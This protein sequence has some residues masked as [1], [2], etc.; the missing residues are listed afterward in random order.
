MQNQFMIISP[1]RFFLL[2]GTLLMSFPTV[3]QQVPYYSA[4]RE[5]WG[6]L[7]PAF[8]DFHY[9]DY[10]KGERPNYYSANISLRHQFA[11][12]NQSIKQ[13]NAKIESRIERSKWGLGLNFDQIG[14]F[15][16]LGV[17]G[18]YGYQV[19]PEKL[20]LAFSPKIT[21]QTLNLKEEDFANFADDQTA[22]QA[23][24]FSTIKTSLDVGMSYANEIGG[25]NFLL[26][27]LGVNNFWAQ[28]T[29][30]ILTLK[31]AP[32]LN[33]FAGFLVSYK[34]N[35]KSAD[36]RQW[37][38]MVLF[39]M[40]PNVSY[41]TFRDF[42]RPIVPSIDFSVRYSIIRDSKNDWR[43]G[44]GL[45]TSGQINFEVSA[46]P[47]KKKF[48]FGINFSIPL[49]NNSLGPGLEIFY[50]HRN[51]YFNQNPK[52]TGKVKF[53]RSSRRGTSNAE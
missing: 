10:V 47:E 22:Q 34:K 26:L 42:E 30:G 13:L 43:T 8:L 3:A 44:A 4:I 36:I 25:K 7:N 18:Q 33:A 53:K 41:F 37:E 24:A 2:L 35:G 5:N 21:L 14:I 23:I 27:G 49:L 1:L 46:F 6:L 31:K 40:V 51:N 48:D 50:V 11:N 12:E 39:R 28:Q 45:S 32:Q 9:Y 20:M 16:E 15:Q 52:R 29:S 38:P 19:L 17:Y